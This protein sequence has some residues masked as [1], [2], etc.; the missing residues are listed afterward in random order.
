MG[1]GRGAE[2]QERRNRW[3]VRIQKSSPRAQTWAISKRWCLHDLLGSFPCL[4][5]CAMGVGVLLIL[6]PP[7]RAQWQMQRMGDSGWGVG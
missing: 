1:W 2:G 5:P 3:Q 7:H 4:G 6:I